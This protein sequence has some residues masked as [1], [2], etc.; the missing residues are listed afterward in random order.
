[1]EQERECGTCGGTGEIITEKC[2]TCHGK[3]YTDNTIKKDIDIPAG[4]EE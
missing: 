3:K 2:G 4:I 1:M